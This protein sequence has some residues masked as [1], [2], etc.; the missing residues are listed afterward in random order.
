MITKF[1]STATIKKKFGDEKP[2]LALSVGSSSG[3]LGKVK[4]SKYEQHFFSKS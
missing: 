3:K 4:C 2:A 1:Q